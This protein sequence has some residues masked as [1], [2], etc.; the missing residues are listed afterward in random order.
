VMLF[1]A[2]IL[3][4]D[5]DDDDEGGN[6]NMRAV[7]LDTAADCVAACAVAVVGAAMLATG[8]NCWLDSADALSI[9]GVVALHALRLVRS[10]VV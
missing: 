6:L 9:S 8:G 2:L 4:G 1:G 5:E 7:L 3:N 10:V